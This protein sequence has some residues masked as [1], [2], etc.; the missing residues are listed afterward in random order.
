MNRCSPVNYLMEIFGR[1]GEG[2]TRRVQKRMKFHG[3]R[4]EEEV[5]Y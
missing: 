4:K 3:I 2:V 1:G 5:L